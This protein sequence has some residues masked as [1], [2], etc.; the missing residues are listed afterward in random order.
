[1]DRY[2]T[3]VWLLPIIF[4]VHDFE[5]IIFFKPW[6]N[7][8]KNYLAEK[9]PKISKRFLDRL[10]SLSTSGFAFA[11]AEEF[12]LLSLITVASVIL[13]KYVL[14]LALFMGFFIHLLLHIGQWI[15]LKRYIPAIWTTF[16]ALI[17]CVYTLHVIISNE[18]FRFSEIVLWA[19]IGL[20]IV[21]GNLIFAHK[22]AGWF[23][24]QK[25]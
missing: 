6:I 2:I 5:E 8:N 14:W 16:F 15:I 25:L 7:K 10:C 3:I 23:D 21:W 11:V 4:M 12:I 17:Y 1:M 20:I 9:F 19:I 13:D 18:I 22:L 24:K